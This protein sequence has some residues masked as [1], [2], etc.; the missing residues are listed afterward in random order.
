[1]LAAGAALRWFSSIVRVW[2]RKAYGSKVPGLRVGDC[3]CGF[4]ALWV[5]NLEWGKVIHW[6]VN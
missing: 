4:T 1:M 6:K 3:G 5:H 2:A